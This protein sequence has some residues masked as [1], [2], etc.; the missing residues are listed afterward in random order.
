MAET[1]PREQLLWRQLATSVLI[2]IASC[3]SMGLV[4]ANPG[5]NALTFCSAL[6]FYQL[7]KF[8]EFI[9][10]VRIAPRPLE[11]ERDRLIKLKGTRSAHNVLVGGIGIIF[12]LLYLWGASLSSACLAGWLF[13][14]FLFSLIVGRIRQ[15]RLYHFHEWLTPDSWSRTLSRR[16]LERMER[17]YQALNASEKPEA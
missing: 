11:D 3:I 17:R 16:T 5:R 15:I 4:P 8:V 13:Y 10:V 1:N 14:L 12:W 9:Y 2:L 6:L 7:I